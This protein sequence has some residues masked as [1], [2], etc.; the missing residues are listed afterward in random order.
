MHCCGK[1][2]PPVEECPGIIRD[3]GE[4]VWV[5]P[6]RSPA[7]DQIDNQ[8]NGIIGQR[9]KCTKGLWTL[10]GDEIET[11][12]EGVKVCAL[13]ESATIG[14]IKWGEDGIED[15]DICRPADNFVPKF[16]CP[17]GWN[18]Y[19]ALTFVRVD[20]GGQGQ[21]CTFTSSS[22]GGKKALTKLI[23]QYRLMRYVR[24]PICVLETKPRNDK[25]GNIDPV[26]K[27]VGW[28]DRSNFGD[29]CGVPAV[30]APM[31]PDPALPAPKQGEPASEIINDEIPF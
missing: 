21:L 13:I 11:G 29:I 12:D 7:W 10:D 22:W 8:S 2:S 30:A 3:S 16:Q 5:G 27:V 15:R 23:S 28:A 9:L 20:E 25:N 1:K 18:P 31:P 14:W 19:T 17:E 26:F 4:L 6:I 24:F